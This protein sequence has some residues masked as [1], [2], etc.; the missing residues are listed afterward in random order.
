[1]KKITIYICDKC[2]DEFRNK[3]HCIKHE[4]HCK[5]QNCEIC[6]HAYHVHGNRYCCDL[7]SNG[8]KCKFESSMHHDDIHLH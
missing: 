2:G 6:C 4:I 3:K 7:L 5:A 8:M 1:M